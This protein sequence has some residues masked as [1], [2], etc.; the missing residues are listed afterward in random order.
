MDEAYSVGDGPAYTTAARWRDEMRLT[1]Q[2][3]DPTAR[4]RFAAK[5]MNRSMQ[6]FGRA[7]VTASERAKAMR[8]A[9]DSAVR[10]EAE[11]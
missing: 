7:M 1:L 2:V 11:S 8:S 5:S 10:P 3:I 4:M 9:V 6:E